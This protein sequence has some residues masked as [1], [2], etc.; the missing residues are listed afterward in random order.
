MR[1][2]GDFLFKVGV[3]VFIFA[4]LFVSGLAMIAYK[5]FFG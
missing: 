3:F 1:G 2:S 5:L 4:A